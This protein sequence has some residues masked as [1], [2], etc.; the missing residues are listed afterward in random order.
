MWWS[1]DRALQLLR[2]GA[3]GVRCGPVVLLR[4]G[5]EGSGRQRPLEVGHLVAHRTL[6]RLGE[7]IVKAIDTEKMA[8]NR[9]ERFVRVWMGPLSLAG[10]CSLVLC[11]SAVAD[12]RCIVGVSNGL[13]CR[14]T[15]VG[16]VC[17]RFRLLS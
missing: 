10:M 12:D 4:P 7:G 3:D 6:G 1:A 14:L 13:V 9:G 16:R 11:G 17:G 8:K 5:M 2:A 15:S